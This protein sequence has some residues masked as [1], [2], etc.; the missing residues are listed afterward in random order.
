[1]V[2]GSNPPAG[3][4]PA[5]DF[6]CYDAYMNGLLEEVLR[7]QKATGGSAVLLSATLPTSIRRDLLKAWECESPDQAPYPT[8]WTAHDEK[9]VPVALPASEAPAER[10]VEVNLSKLEGAFPDEI[11]LGR[12][13]EAARAGGLVGIVMNTVDHAQRLARL[14][15]TQA[16]ETPVDLFH[17]RF[18]LRDRQEI[19]RG[20]INRYGRD[21]DRSAGRILVATQVIEQSLDLDFDWLVTQ[22]CPVDLLFQRLGR[23]HRHERAYRP[24]GHER[25][26]CTVLAMKDE[27]YGLHKLIYGDPRLLWRTERLLGANTQIRF[28][29]AYREWI[30]HVYNDDVWQRGSW[31]DEPEQISSDHYAWVQERKTARAEAQHLTTMTV[32]KFRDEDSRTTSLTRDGEMSLS[33]LPMLIGKC[34]LDGTSV[35]DLDERERAEVLLLNTV[36][37]P[38]SWET[39]L[40]GC[41]AND[42]VYDGRYLL[43][44]SGAEDCAWIEQDHRL[45]YSTAY[46]LE[47][48]DEP[49]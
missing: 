37:A 13:I 21:A 12:I 25:P 20:V 18:R 6:H 1:M 19:E 46:G 3:R 40:S 28:P 8:L 11:L 41:R 34:L 45:R 16:G 4:S 22:L 26:A 47:K 43:E 2:S 31:D 5:A 33:V 15:R 32:S 49:A 7:R 24:P 30:E 27:D 36:P 42:E 44:M 35:Q 23:L 9:A 10:T 14:L 48:M 29:D 39:C 38:A 17:A